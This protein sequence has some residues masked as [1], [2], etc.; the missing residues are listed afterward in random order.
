M[1]L[2]DRGC[3]DVAPKGDRLLVFWADRVVHG[4]LP[5]YAPRGAEDHRVA[6]TVWI[7]SLAEATRGRGACVFQHF[8]LLFGG[9]G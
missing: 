2:D 8:L 4:V 5:A 9:G 6:L 7:P 1:F 3:V